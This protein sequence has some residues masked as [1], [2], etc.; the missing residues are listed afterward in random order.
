[1]T[2]PKLDLEEA[3]RLCREATEG[4]WRVGFTRDKDAKSSRYILQVKGLRSKNP[5]NWTVIVSGCE[6]SWDI[7]QGVLNPEDAAFIAFARTFVPL[8]VE[9]IRE[10]EEE[11]CLARQEEKKP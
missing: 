8:A 11:R 6:D 3:E 1:M 7:P 10:L 4:P 9:R 2:I 5:D